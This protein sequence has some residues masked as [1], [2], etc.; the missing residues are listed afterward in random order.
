MTPDEEN[1]LVRRVKQALDD[2][3]LTMI[4]PIDPRTGREQ[5]VLCDNE[6]YGPGLVRVVPL[7]TLDPLPLKPFVEPRRGEGRFQLPEEEE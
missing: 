2:K 5:T 3:R 7:A 1:H 6:P 4:Y